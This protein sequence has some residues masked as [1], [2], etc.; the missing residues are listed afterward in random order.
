MCQGCSNSTYVRIIAHFRINVLIIFTLFAKSFGGT[1]FADSRDV[2]KWP[3][4]R[5]IRSREKRTK[6]QEMR[7]WKTLKTRTSRKREP[8]Q[9]EGDRATIEEDL[10]NKVDASQA[11]EGKV[12]PADGETS[13][14]EG[15]RL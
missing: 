8:S 10:G 11:T 4:F 13:Q 2:E 14:A 7:L 5:G 9:A 6:E 15:E 1:A 12:I 3:G